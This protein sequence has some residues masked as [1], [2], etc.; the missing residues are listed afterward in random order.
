MVKIPHS[1]ISNSA[2]SIGSIVTY[3]CQNGYRFLDTQHHIAI[4]CTDQRQW[5]D[6]VPECKGEAHYINGI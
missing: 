5:N 3:Q 1:I 2:A 6:T 4:E